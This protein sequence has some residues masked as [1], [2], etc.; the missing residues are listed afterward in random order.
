MKAPCC[1][2]AITWLVAWPRPSAA[3]DAAS[4][5]TSTQTPTR[6]T[7]VAVKLSPRDLELAAHLDLLEEMELFEDFDLLK[8]LPALEE[9]NDER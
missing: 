9:D 5:V 4:I 1:I 2:A 7:F 6:T 3:E 8:L